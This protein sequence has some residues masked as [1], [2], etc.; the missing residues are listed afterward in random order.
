[1][2]NNKPRASTALSIFNDTLTYSISAEVK[3][4]VLKYQYIIY[5]FSSGF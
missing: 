3:E 1:M 2:V 4:I 5:S